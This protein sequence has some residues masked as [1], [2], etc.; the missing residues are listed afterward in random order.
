MTRPDWDRVAL[1]YDGIEITPHL[2]SR[3]RD[4]IWYSSFDCASA[5]RREHERTAHSLEIPQAEPERRISF[6]QS[7]SGFARAR[8]IQDAMA[9]AE[10]A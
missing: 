10:G 2:W 3:R 4:H 5:A 7:M 1:E 6:A 9:K 8:R